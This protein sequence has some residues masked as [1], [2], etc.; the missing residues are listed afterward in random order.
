MGGD[1]WRRSNGF[2]ISWQ[3]PP[4][5]Y[6]PITRA[7]YELC[8]PEA[9]S[10]G[11]S[12]G[13]GGHG[14][15]A[16]CGRVRRLHAPGLA[17]GEAGN[18]SYALSASDAVHLRLDQEPPRWPSSRRTRPTPARRGT[19]G[20]PPLRPRHRSDRDAPPRGRLSGNP[21]PRPGGSARWSATWTTSGSAQAH[22]SSAPAPVTSRETRARRTGR[23]N[24]ARAT[25]EPARALR[26]PPQPSG[27]RRVRRRQ[28]EPDDRARARRGSGTAARLKLHRPPGER[29]RPADRRRHDPG[30]EPTL[31]ATPWAASRGCRPHRPRRSGSATSSG[32]PQQGPAV[33][34]PG[35]RRIRAATRDFEL[36][37]PGVELD[38]GA[39]ARPSRTDRPC[40]P[41]RPGA[42]PPA[43]P[44]REA[45]RGSGYFRGRFRTFS[46]TRAQPRVGWTLRLSF[47]GTRGR[48]PYRLRV[49]FPPRAAIR[50]TRGSSPV[51]RVV[52][53]ARASPLPAAM[54]R[55]SRSSTTTSPPP[56]PT[57]PRSASTTSCRSRRS[58]SRS[59]SAAS[60]SRAAG[61]P[62]RSPT[63][64]TR[65]S[66]RSSAAPPSTGSCRS[67]GPTPGRPTRSTRC[68]PPFRPADRPHRRLLARRVPPG[69]RRGPGSLRDRQRGDRRRR[70]R[71][72]SERAS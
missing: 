47:G 20:R 66:P 65:A 56:T 32:H 34:L 7:W 57:S 23:A 50:S 63:R 31:P 48:V 42:H 2:A 44:L 24:G 49:R 8:G 70:L 38:P 4:Q 6:A 69:V 15:R 30:L 37:V 62:G 13:R 45:G 10:V 43:A 29:G 58:G 5:A 16:D 41:Q 53:A 39:A 51:A 27:A 54:P 17:R 55:T 9:C 71:A 35:S 12:T 25:I 36:H 40:S 28:A 1:A 14:E 19:R 26:H 11:R 18:Q 59:S 68:G 64:A 52:V 72:P 61:S 3:T 67:A 60:G 22:T 21:S 46:T 33:S